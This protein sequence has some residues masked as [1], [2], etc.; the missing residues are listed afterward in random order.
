MTRTFSRCGRRSRPIADAPAW[1]AKAA[2]FS[3]RSF[4]ASRPFPFEADSE[5]WREGLRKGGLPESFD[6]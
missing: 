1:L 5:H 3:I 2:D 4:L 6:H